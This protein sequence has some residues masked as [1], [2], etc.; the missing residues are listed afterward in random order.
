MQSN[1]I[2]TSVV[3]TV[4]S[5]LAMPA[6]SQD[7]DKLVK[8]GKIEAAD[9]AAL[10]QEKDTSAHAII[11]SDVGDSDFDVDKDH[12]VVIF[13]RH[14]RVKIVDANG[15]DAATIEVPLY[16]DGNEAEKM[17]NLKASVYSLENGKIV[18]T[19]LDSKSVF[20]E[21]EGEHI[22]VKKFTMPA[23]KPGVIFEYSY[24]TTSPWFRDIPTW[25]FQDEYPELYS[26]YSVTIPECFSF[27]FIRQ[28]YIRYEKEREATNGRHTYNL[29]FENH[30]AAGP[31]EHGTYEAG[32]STFHWVAKDVPALKE[33][34]FTTT[35]NNH[36]A[37]IEFQLSSVHYP[38][39]PVKPYMDT[40]AGVYEKLNESEYFGGNLSKNN[41]FL[42]DQVDALTK[43]LTAD[44]AK[45][46]AIYNYVRDNYT[47]SDHSRVYMDKTLKTT[48]TSHNG[49][50]A[51]INLLLVAML[52]K[53]GLNADPVMMST[54]AHGFINPMY[55]LLN[56]FNYVVASVNAETGTYFMDASLNYLGFGRLDKRCY[57]GGARIISSSIPAISF[58]ADSLLEQNSSFVILAVDS[59]GIHGSIQQKPTYF[60]SCSIR[61]DIKEKGN[62]SYFKSLSKS[63]GNDAVVSNVTVNGLDN[64]EEPL[65][66]SYDFSYKTDDEGIIY[67]NPMLSEA[68]KTNPFKS[69]ER[70]YP[71]EMPYVSD[72][73]YTL[74][75]TLPD[76][77]EVDE[78]PKPAMVKLN[79]TDGLFQYLIQ[80]SGNSIQF[81]C[82]LKLNKATF[83]PEEY[84]SLRQFYDMVVKKES[85][86]IV[87]KRKA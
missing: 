30:G 58:D 31:T 83:A 7:K 32:I 53:A 27:V 2:V 8:F 10:P 14:R 77:Y 41:G 75:F 48:F 33:E 39:Q 16:V 29:A 13:K 69:A 73:L 65:M 28:G 38:E 66:L 79:E 60:E 3:L 76:G 59:S 12:F 86:Q 63:L 74:N 84:E 45:A 72:E 17:S 64:K 62:D 42:G 35:I 70:F 49:S 26:D 67:L 46:R 81:R 82:R 6:R 80:Q 18:E 51:E 44:T 5:L 40:W 1:F 47:C 52:R 61:G 25:Y 50:E 19:K 78:L 68:Y 15:Y 20:T 54:R 37:K 85:E 43:G 23:L 9:F 34:S 87:L 57:N 21:K 71:V 4:V 11:L 55:P 24:T 36:I 56:R 22:I